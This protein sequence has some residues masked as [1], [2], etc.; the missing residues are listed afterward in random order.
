MADRHLA[1][2]C[3]VCFER[4]DE[5]THLP[6]LLN[7]SHTLC[8]LCIRNLRAPITCP[9]C[10]KIST[11][12][13]GGPPCNY[14]LRDLIV[15]ERHEA[16]IQD[17]ICE[18]HDKKHR[19]THFCSQCTQVMCEEMAKA[20]KKS[21]GTQSHQ[22]VPISEKSKEICK[23]VFCEKHNKEVELF[24]EQDGSLVCLLCVATTHYGHCCKIIEDAFERNRILDE[25][26][27][28]RCVVAQ[29]D[30]TFEKMSGLK[31]FLEESKAEVTAKV[32]AYFD[33]QIRLCQLRR[34]QLLTTISATTKKKIR[35]LK[36]EEN[37]IGSKLSEKILLSINNLEGLVKIGDKLNAL[38]SRYQLQQQ[39]KEVDVQKQLNFEPVSAK[40]LLFEFVNEPLSEFT[41]TKVVIG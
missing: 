29:I 28:A 32:N 21:R 11:F 7:C 6:S 27:E 33:E 37:E 39:I 36:R 26:F 22:I 14:T 19:A 12:P 38:I 1:L 24:C 9:M 30:T 34:E 23:P 13:E 18:F 10:K 16:D 17:D 20:H 15:S 4:Y 8:L 2:E 35:I 40:N 31:P 5:T 3:P 41:K 25:I